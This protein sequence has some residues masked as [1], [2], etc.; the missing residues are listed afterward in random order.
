MVFA[1]A[2]AWGLPAVVVHAAGP[3]CNDG[4]EGYHSLVQD[5]MGSPPLE[6]SYGAY[7]CK[8][9]T[10]YF[11]WNCVPDY[12]GNLHPDNV[13]YSSTFCQGAYGIRC[14]SSGSCH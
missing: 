14:C 1:V 8:I 5:I 4:V 9:G 7:Q 12:E 2:I 3:N 10:Q 6:C 11:T 13:T